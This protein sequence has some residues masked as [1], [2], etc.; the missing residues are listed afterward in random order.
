M[1]EVHSFKI[2]YLQVFGFEC[3]YVKHKDTKIDKKLFINCPVSMKLGKNY[4]SLCT[5]CSGSKRDV[6]IMHMDLLPNMSVES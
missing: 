3:F 6:V 2:I 5:L 4:C 1:Q